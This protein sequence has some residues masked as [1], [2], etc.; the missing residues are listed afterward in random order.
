MQVSRLKVTASN[1]DGLTDILVDAGLPPRIA[2]LFKDMPYRTVQVDPRRPFREPGASRD[3]VMFVRS[4]I[5]CKYKMDSGGRRQIVA[6]RFPGEGILPHDGPAPYGVQA[7]V[8]SEVIVG[9]AKPGPAGG[10]FPRGRF[11]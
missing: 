1:S 5:L 4:G 11:F 3:E 10:G 6:L 2:L 8:R 9:A 7:V